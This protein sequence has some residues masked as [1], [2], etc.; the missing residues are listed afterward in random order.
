MPTHIYYGIYRL[1]FYSF[2][3]DLEWNIAY[4]LC[5][6]STSIKCVR[7]IQSKKMNVIAKHLDFVHSVPTF[8]IGITYNLFSLA[9]KHIQFLLFHVTYSFITHG[10][11]N[12]SSLPIYSYLSRNKFMLALN[13][14]AEIIIWS[15]EVRPLG[16]MLA[17]LFPQFIHVECHYVK[18]KW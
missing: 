1:K 7:T 9:L 17:F 16:L 3:F 4:I 18:L 6:F 15:G 11:I 10:N 5:N 8:L 12:Y 2:C 14:L 13:K